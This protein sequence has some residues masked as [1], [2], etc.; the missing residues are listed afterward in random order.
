MC[1]LSV[2]RSC[3]ADF[4][5]AAAYA[6]TFALQPCPSGASLTWAQRPW[7]V[8]TTRREPPYLGA[9]HTGT[10]RQRGKGTGTTHGGRAGRTCEALICDRLVVLLGRA[11]LRVQ[12][13]PRLSHPAAAEKLAAVGRAVRG[14]LERQELRRGPGG[15]VSLAASAVQD[16]GRCG[17][18]GTR[19]AAWCVCPSPGQHGDPR[20]RACASDHP[21]LG[22]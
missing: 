20:L 10:D 4:T 9:Q 22:H 8:H 16:P 6:Q 5:L 21:G 18:R 7:M 2:G 1:V 13:F 17:H 19:A 15:G 3:H 14:K 11:D 12:L